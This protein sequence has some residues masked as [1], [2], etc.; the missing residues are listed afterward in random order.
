MSMRKTTLRIGGMHCAACSSALERRLNKQEGIKASVNLALEE[1]S[2]EYDDRKYDLGMIAK[3]IEKTG[4]EMLGENERPPFEERSRTARLVAAI[5]LD[6]L[7]LYVAM[8]PMIHLPSPF[9]ENTLSSAVVQLVLVLPIMLCGYTFFTRGF[10]NLFRLRPNMDS[11]V[12]LGTTASF[13]FSLYNL[14]TG[15]LHHSLYF[16]G[17]GTIITLVMLGKTLEA[18][19]KKKSAKA[20]EDLVALQPDHAVRINEDGSLEDINLKQIVIGDT[21]LIRP[22][23]KIPCDGTVTEGHCSIDEAMLTGESLPADK[24][25]GDKVFGSTLN[26]GTT[27]KMRADEVGKDTAIQKII[28]MVKDA[29]GTKA[30]I[31]RIADK[32]SLYFVP[33]VMALA[34]LTFLLWAFLGSDAGLAIT[35]AVAVLVIACPCALGLA[36]PIAIMVASGKAA[37]CGILFRN[38]EALETLGRSD[39]FVFDKTGTL[40]EG[41]L[42]IVESTLDG[43]SS[44]L[45]RKIESLSEHPIAKAI[46]GDSKTASDDI[47]DFR[48]V[49]GLGCRALY[50]GYK[51]LAGSEKLLESEGINNF[52]RAEVEAATVVYLAIDGKVL[53]HVALSDTVRQDAEE[54]IEKLH[55]LGKKTVMITGDNES[56][57]RSVAGKLGIDR[58]YASVL[59]SGKK[60]IVSKLKEEGKVVYIGDGINDSPALAEADTALSVSNASDVA[61]SSSSV[62]LVSNRLDDIITSYQLS[63]FTM[64]NIKENLFWAFFY[65]ALGIPV[66]AGLLTIFGG[67]SLNPMLASLAMS[68]S[69]VTVVSNALRINTFRKNR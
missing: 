13:L 43:K 30:P 32:V 26:T 4:F 37:K 24:G 53:G 31:A 38:A 14:L 69:S 51:V 6:V 52:E 49:P 65:N 29:Q 55:K 60:D 47:S 8:G 66:A 41:K 35:H 46:T 23:D 36:T 67:P 50:E 25:V 57:A 21:L 54:T 33:T 9:G 62:V 5:V 20:I 12:A 11:L 64:R 17:A 10:G 68:L 2:I 15:N 44:E 48:S 45:L 34:L 58:F 40:T 59:P 19:S 18:S 16:E 39:I 7:L 22:G 28:Q 42:F 61:M 27:F 56:T 63:R 3:I 1:A